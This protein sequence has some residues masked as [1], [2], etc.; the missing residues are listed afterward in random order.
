M[1]IEGKRNGEGVGH[2]N[3]NSTSGNLC[4]CFGQEGGGNVNI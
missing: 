2:E 3:Y 1:N 4:S